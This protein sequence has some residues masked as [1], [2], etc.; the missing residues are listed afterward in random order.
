M[1]LA[2]P[3]R[4]IKVV[5]VEVDGHIIRGV[6]ERINDVVLVTTRESQQSAPLNGRTP[7]AVAS[8]LLHQLY[9]RLPAG[10]D[11]IARALDPVQ[12]VRLRLQSE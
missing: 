7:E 2:G 9:M 12:T 10:E 8:D 11:R 3:R 1:G 6:V 5:E 4:P